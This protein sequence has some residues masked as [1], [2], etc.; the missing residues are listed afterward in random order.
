MME[1]VIIKGSVQWRAIESC[2]EYPLPVGSY[3]A[4]DKTLFSTKKY[5]YFSYTPT[6]TYVE[7]THQK[8]LAEALLMSTHNT[9]FRREI[10]KLVTWYPLLSRP[11]GIWT[12]NFLKKVPAEKWL[13]E[14]CQTPTD[15]PFQNFVFVFLLGL[16][17]NNR[18][19]PYQLV[20]FLVELII[21]LSFHQVWSFLYLYLLNPEEQTTT[22]FYQIKRLNP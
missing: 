7:G 21:Y 17:L 1:N 16:W 2:A 13:S 10:R 11:M 20:S 14:R 6:K 15:S 22:Q 9:C 12:L 19:W 18:V 5:L 4:L 3:I 8:R